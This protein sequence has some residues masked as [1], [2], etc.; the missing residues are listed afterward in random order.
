MPSHLIRMDIEAAKDDLKNRTLTPIGYDF[1]RL[2]YL[3]SLRDYSSGEYRHYG[4]AHSFSEHAANRALAACHEEVFYQLALGSLESLVTQIERFVRS[5]PQDARKTVDTWE[6]LEVF[7]F[8]L[9]SPCHPLAS[10]LFMSNIKVAMSLL[11]SR[12]SV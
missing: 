12:T 10:A 1:G 4:L 3:A 11:R 2:V 9:P 6:S 5:V 7:R 8:A